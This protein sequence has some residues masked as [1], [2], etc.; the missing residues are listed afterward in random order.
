MSNYEIRNDDDLRLW[1]RIKSIEKK[2]DKLGPMYSKGFDWVEWE[3][4]EEESAMYV[5]QLSIYKDIVK[6][7]VA[8]YG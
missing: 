4:L 2:I 6:S 8:K 5:S 7:L 3:S 1:F